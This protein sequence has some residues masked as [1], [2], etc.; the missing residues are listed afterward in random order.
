MLFAACAGERHDLSL[1]A[2][3]L[4]AAVTGMRPIYVGAD[5]PAPDVA[6]LMARTPV[7]VVMIGVV[8]C[9]DQHHLMRE[10]LAIRSACLEGTELWIGGNLPPGVVEAIA[11]P[12]VIEIGRAH[13]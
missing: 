9:P 10:L 4:L 2:A 12:G 7:D 13:V 8:Y 1:Q 3:A 11:A 6:A 5:T